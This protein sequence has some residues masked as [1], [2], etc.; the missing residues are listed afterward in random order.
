MKRAW[1]AEDGTAFDKRMD[2]E[3]YEASCRPPIS[4]PWDIFCEVLRQCSPYM[5]KAQERRDLKEALEKLVPQPIKQL[6]R[7]RNK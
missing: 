2:C 4:I 6:R 1:L 3:A 5:V 7:E